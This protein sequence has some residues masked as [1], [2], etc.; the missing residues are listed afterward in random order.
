MACVL[1]SEGGNL[2]TWRVV[3]WNRAEVRQPRTT[4]L[5]SSG[6]SSNGWH[7]NTMLKLLNFYLVRSRHCTAKCGTQRSMQ[8]VPLHCAGSVTVT[9]RFKQPARLIG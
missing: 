1:R 3:R 4:I 8:I 2:G 6:T 7:T 9:A 5:G